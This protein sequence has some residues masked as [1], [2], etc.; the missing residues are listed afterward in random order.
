[1]PVPPKFP[2]PSKTH[3]HTCNDDK[4]FNGWFP[5]AGLPECVFP[6]HCSQAVDQLAYP[7]AF[8]CSFAALI[9]LVNL[10]NAPFLSMPMSFC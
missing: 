10:I 2:N 1:M 8:G 9:A 3:V 6:V 5:V 7:S 4:A